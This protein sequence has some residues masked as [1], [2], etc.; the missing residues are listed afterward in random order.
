MVHTLVDW[1]RWSTMGVSQ[2]PSR[3]VQ[4]ETRDDPG[5]EELL[6][7]HWFLIPVQHHQPASHTVQRVL[8]TP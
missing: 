6:L 8:F 3:Q 4:L 7:G 5:R 2:N 1:L